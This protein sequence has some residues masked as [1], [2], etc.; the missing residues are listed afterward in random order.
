MEGI[1]LDLLMLAIGAAMPILALLLKAL[2]SWLSSKT[3]N[4]QLKKLLDMVESFLLESIEKVGD[5]AVAELKS[6]AADGKLTYDEAMAT[7]KEVIKDAKNKAGEALRS[8]LNSLGLDDLDDYL[9]K[10]I[11]ELLKERK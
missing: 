8:K 4:K 3:K 9:D 10:K 5:P 11:E 6:K 2:I 7:K 1:N